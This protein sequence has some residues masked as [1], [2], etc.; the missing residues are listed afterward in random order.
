MV[1]SNKE[2]LKRC[3]TTVIETILFPWD[4]GLIP[5]QCDFFKKSFSIKQCRCV[6]RND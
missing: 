6:L 5:S 2:Q 3:S 4:R 1:K